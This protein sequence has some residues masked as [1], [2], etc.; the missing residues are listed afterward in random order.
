[1][2]IGLPP[3]VV[4][5]RQLLCGC[6]FQV[7]TVQIGVPDSEW[8]PRFG[9]GCDNILRFDLYMC[10][11]CM[12]SSITHALLLLIHSHPLSLSVPLLLFIPTH[13]TAQL[14]GWST[15]WL[16]PRPCG[17]TRFQGGRQ[18]CCNKEAEQ[19]LVGKSLTLANQKKPPPLW[20]SN[21]RNH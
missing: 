2:Y 6:A 1:M 18:N 20:Q 13:H 15:V 8:V 11:V 5:A 14:S 21:Y 7:C 17:W 19:G 3:L 10:L 16:W 9:I 12:H 4:K